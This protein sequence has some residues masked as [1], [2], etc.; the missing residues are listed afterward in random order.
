MFACLDMHSSIIGCLSQF[1][2]IFDIP[3]NINFDC[4]TSFMSAE[5]SEY[6]RNKGMAF[7]H[8]TSYNRQATIQVERLNGTLWMAISLVVEVRRLPLS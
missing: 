6:A 4:G 3:A 1:S 7:S 2:T 5:L 8:T